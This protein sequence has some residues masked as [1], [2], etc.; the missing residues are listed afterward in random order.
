[1]ALSATI[2]G[3]G[4]LTLSRHNRCHRG[5]RAVACLVYGQVG[6]DA[7]SVASGE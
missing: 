4:T 1:M 5:R 3:N 2:F 6:G 7:R